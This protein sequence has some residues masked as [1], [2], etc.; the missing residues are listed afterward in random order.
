TTFDTSDGDI[1]SIADQVVAWIQSG[2]KRQG[3]AS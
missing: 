2:Y 1:D 3:E